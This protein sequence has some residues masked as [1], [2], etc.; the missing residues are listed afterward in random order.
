MS[1]IF[2]F[3]FL[4]FLR[5][6]LFLWLPMSILVL[7]NPASLLWSRCLE[8]LEWEPSWETLRTSATT[9]WTTKRHRKYAWAHL[10][11]AW[12]AALEHLFKRICCSSSVRTSSTGHL[13]KCL[14]KDLFDVAISEK[15]SKNF[16]RVYIIKV[17]NSSRVHLR[18]KSIVV[19]T[20]SC[21]SKTTVSCAYF[22]ECF[23][24]AR[25]SVFVRVYF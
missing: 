17:W 12:S 5:L 8:L 16:L 13:A 4:L 10:L 22:F 2:F 25:S 20:L 11:H 21:V 14:R 19:T 6:G 15:L 9:H 7:V 1:K 18:S 23:L 3:F 24:G